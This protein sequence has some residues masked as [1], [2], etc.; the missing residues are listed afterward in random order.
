MLSAL[1][2]T[3]DGM[4]AIGLMSGTSLDGIDVALLETDGERVLET[5]PWGTTAYEP[6]L[7]ARLRACL[8][9]P[10]G[11]HG[12]LEADL[13][14]AHRDVVEGFLAAHGIGRETVDLVGFHGQTILHRPERRFTKQ[15][16]DGSRLARSL[17]IDVVNDFRHADVAAGG[18]GAPLASLYHRTLAVDLAPRLVV[19]NLGG[20]A[21]VTYLDGE[22]VLAFDT[23][24]ANALVDDWVLV[25]TGKRYDEGGELAAAGE[26]HEG[27]LAQLMDN[28]YFALKP[29][30]SLDRNDFPVDAVDGFSLEDGAATLSAF[31]V[32]SVAAARA[33]FPGVA[34]RW[35]VTGGGRHNRTLMTWLGAALERPVEP[36]EVVG[37]QGDGL[38][39]QAF[40]FLAV[41]SVLG[42]PLSVPGTTGVPRP[43]PGGV[44]HRARK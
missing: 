43:M 33:H 35:L 7:R 37:W 40:A 38:E 30:K 1:N 23:G 32:R 19:L 11:D 9:A 12:Q 14:D 41:R 6:A 15:L 29:P 8:E 20:V 28:G 3:G 16:G 18:Q 39:A 17:G 27:V 13:T 5:G 44:L 42:L 21:N 4:R 10:D 36:V 2:K 24:P 34:E 25:R 26:V 22:T 31:T